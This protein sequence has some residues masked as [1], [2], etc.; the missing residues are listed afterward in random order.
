MP[1]KIFPRGFVIASNER[2]ALRLSEELRLVVDALSPTVHA[3]WRRHRK[4]K[5]IWDASCALTI[6]GGSLQNP[7]LLCGKLVLAKT[8]PY[9]THR[10]LIEPNTA[11]LLSTLL[12]PENQLRLGRALQLDASIRRCLGLESTK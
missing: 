1:T 4:D 5:R 12:E 8:R 2:E 3:V 11:D 10:P 6:A 7:V 9:W